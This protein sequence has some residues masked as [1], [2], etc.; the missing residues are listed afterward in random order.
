MT[1]IFR[2]TDF[3]AG[4]CTRRR[5]GLRH[6]GTVITNISDHLLSDWHYMTTLRHGNGVDV[7]HKRLINISHWVR[8]FTPSYIQGSKRHFLSALFGNFVW[9]HTK[10]FISRDWLCNL[11]MAASITLEYVYRI[12]VLQAPHLY[13]DFK[14]GFAVGLHI[15]ITKSLLWLK[16]EFWSCAK[17]TWNPAYDSSAFLLWHNHITKKKAV[18][19]IPKEK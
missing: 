5:V 11:Q 1:L 9:L 13:E 3:S 12:S 7:S 4:Y 8:E 16:R 15:F 2:L 18:P 6:L 14:A 19:Y 17:S 10:I